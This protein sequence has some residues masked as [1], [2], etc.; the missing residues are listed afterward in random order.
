MRIPSILVLAL[1]C[2]GCASQHKGLYLDH[3]K[4]IMRLDG[5][6]LT[7]SELDAL[8]QDSSTPEMQVTVIENGKKEHGTLTDLRIAQK[9][10]ETI[11]SGMRKRIRPLEPEPSKK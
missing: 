7:E 10:A 4:G 9:F 2:A 1:V 11:V 5:R 3:D 8:L 6:A